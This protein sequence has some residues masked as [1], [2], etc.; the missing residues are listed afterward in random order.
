M[1]NLNIAEPNAKQKEF[2]LA[3]ERFIAYGGARGGGKSWAVRYKAILLA[4]KYCGIRI[5]LLRKSFPELRE[6]HIIP[7]CSILKGIA[8]YREVDKAFSFPNG[9]RIK[10]GYCDNDNDVL[11]YQGQEYDVI[12]MDEATHFTEFQFISLTASLRGANSFPKRMYLTCNP[13]GVGHTWVKRL[14]IDRQFKETEDPADY[15]F[16]KATV[17]DNPA[18]LEADSGYVNMLRNLP[19]T[20]RK[21]WL[22][23]S[24]DIF[25]GQYFSEWNEEIHTTAPFEIPSYWRRYFAMDY[26]MDMLAAYWIAVNEQGRSFVYRELYESGLTVSEAAVKIRAMQ[27]KD[28][29]I[30]AYFAPPDLWNRNRDTGRSTAEIFASCGIPLVKVSNNRVQGW[31]EVHEYLKPCLDEQGVKT[32]GLVVFRNCKN[33]IRTLP[34]L[35][36]DD[37][38]PNDCADEPHELTHAPD[39]IRYYCSGR[40]RAASVA[41]KRDEDLIDYDDQVQAL[42]SFVC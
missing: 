34:A 39:A 9:S 27:P 29:E 6:N 8:D 28:E 40:P 37:K 18:L 21:A 24:W 4:L 33:L 13:G 41:V 14:F 26:G 36:F 31:L 12:F 2:F 3:E 16:I 17:Y 25:E 7:L 23:G 38:N 19:E 11:Q 1:V 30:T 42:L 35:I 32:A 5:L 22:D 10:L 20:Q 15:R